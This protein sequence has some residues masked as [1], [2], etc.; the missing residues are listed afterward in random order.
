MTMSHIPV[1][2]TGAGSTDD[3]P[4]SITFFGAPFQAIGE[5]GLGLPERDTNEVIR[6][7]MRILGFILSDKLMAETPKGVTNKLSTQIRPRMSVEPGRRQRTGVD[8][9]STRG[10][11]HILEILQGA[12]TEVGDDFEAEFGGQ[13]TNM[14][15]PQVEKFRY[16]GVVGLGRRP[17]GGMPPWKLLRPWVMRKWNLTAK[18]SNHAA[19]SLAQHIRIR[20][21]KPNDFIDRV[22]QESRPAFK[23]AAMKIGRNVQVLS[24]DRMQRQFDEGAVLASMD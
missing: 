8:A 19:F 18:E 21:T 5:A 17:G 10:D 20:G 9:S 6:K 14:G 11:V 13:E 12:S 15:R 7:E 23:N 16:R 2:G 4:F 3:L 22:V 1:R 24:T